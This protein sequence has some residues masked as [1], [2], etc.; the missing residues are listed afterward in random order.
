MFSGLPIWL[1]FFLEIEMGTAVGY[2]CTLEKDAARIMNKSE[3]LNS[4]TFAVR[5]CMCNYVMDNS[6]GFLTI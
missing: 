4:S 1:L 5:Q 2:F 3:E 6:E